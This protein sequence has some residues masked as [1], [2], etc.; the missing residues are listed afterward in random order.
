MRK[1]L[2]KMPSPRSLLAFDAAARLGSFTLAAEELNMQQ[3]SVSAAIKQLEQAL[4]C[5]LF[6]R[7]HRKVQ[8]TPLG[9]KLFVGVD[10]GLAEIEQAV[11]SIRQVGQSD[12]VT[13]NS[14]SA[15]SYYWMIPRLNDLHAQYPDIDLRMQTSDREPDL[16][17]ENIDLAIRLGDGV[18]PGCHSVR[19]ADEV[20]MPVA[21]PAVLQSAAS[22]DVVPDLATQRLIHLEEP[23]RVRPTW[24]QW[25]AHHG[26]EEVAPSAG[27]RFNDYAMV[28]QAAVSGE[29]FAFGWEH[30]VRNLVDRGLLTAKSEWAWKTG[31]GIYLVWSS[32]RP[33]ANQAAQVR[34][35]IISV[36]DNPNASS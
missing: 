17:V 25:F 32:T 34:D 11:A 4:G 5:Q 24:R 1:N 6:E 30:I 9:E 28:L 20:I 33:L 27:L 15:F 22:L 23:I 19:I 2:K 35:W 14:S 8:L 36:S 26:A 7:G 31:N 12:Y 29:G 10:R 21:S 3:P 16:D 13:L 18:Y